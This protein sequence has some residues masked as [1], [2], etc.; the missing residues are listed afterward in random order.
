MI[1]VLS[2]DRRTQKTTWLAE[3]SDDMMEVA[4][5]R[6]LDAEI[7]AND[8]DPPLEIVVLSAESK[9]ALERTH[10]RYFGLDSLRK[11]LRPSETLST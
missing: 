6:R 5:Q 10:S 7:A 2:F 11:Q 3:L 9:Y 1:Y 8:I 4:Q